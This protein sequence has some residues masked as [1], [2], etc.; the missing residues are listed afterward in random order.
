M[1]V[2]NAFRELLRAVRWHRRLVAG[3]AAAVAAYFGLAALSPGP[4]PT[5]AVVAAA[6]DLPGG[7]RPADGDLRTVRLPPGAVP[8][9]AV[10]PGDDLRARVLAAPVRAGEPLTDARFV[11]PGLLR[12][13]GAVA[14][15]VRIDDAEVAGLLRVGDR[16]DLFAAGGESAVARLVAS[17]VRVLALPAAPARGVSGGSGALLVLAV[18]PAS[19]A[20]IA[21]AAVDTKLSVALTA[22]DPDG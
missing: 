13:A 18:P 7:S 17:G 5:V 4:P 3:L 1:T 11:A 8:A 21:Q 9:G 2:S 6:R 20:V 16:I 14:Y 10:R 12:Q 22:E 19:A 15:P